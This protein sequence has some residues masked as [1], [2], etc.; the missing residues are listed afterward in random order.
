MDLDALQRGE[1]GLGNA[2]GRAGLHVLSWGWV[3]GHGVRR[4]LFR[5]GVP[6]ARHLP[7]PVI[8]VGNIAVGGT[9]KTP[10]V[11][12]LVRRLVARGQ[13]PGILARGY[14]DVLLSRSEGG[15]LNDEGLVLRYQL[16]PEIPQVQDPDRHAGGRA[17]L[18][19]HPEVDVLILDDGFQHWRLAR[20]LDIVMLDALCPFGHGYRLPR[21]R[22][23]DAPA[24][25]ARAGAVVINRAGHLDDGART[26]LEARVRRHSEAPVAYVDVE[27]QVLVR[28]DDHAEPESLAGAAVHAVCGLGQPH[29]FH[30]TLEGLGACIVART[31]MADHRGLSEAGW[32]RVR[33][34]ASAAGA[35][36]IVITRKD[37]VKLQPLPPDLTVLDVGL[38]CLSGRDA[39]LD[40]VEQALVSAAQR[41][42]G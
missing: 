42:V 30:T 36:R 40:A 35:D 12:W 15:P 33:E 23:R 7:A 22:L 39:L 26:A 31:Q 17:L 9:G 21:G 2:L 29:G 28:G 19:A 8:S 41:Y 32:S 1:P 38:R 16:G 24:A 18:A 13:H 25:L 34:E 5:L 3:L 10:F 14:G 11:A 6:P 20:D 4:G 37:A 27:P